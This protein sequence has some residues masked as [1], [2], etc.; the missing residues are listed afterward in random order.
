MKQTAVANLQVEQRAERDHFNHEPIAS[1]YPS[2]LLQPAGSSQQ[3]QRASPVDFA[4]PFPVPRGPQA[5]CSAGTVGPI[6][7]PW[8]H[9]PPSASYRR[10]CSRVALFICPLRTRRLS[11]VGYVPC[12]AEDIS[13]TS[14]GGL[15]VGYI[16]H[17]HAICDCDHPPNCPLPGRV[18]G[19]MSES[20][21]VISFNL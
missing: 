17:T 20:R 12:T 16:N 14:H 6:Q 1:L 5:S 21:K 7:G 4:V 13:G 15:C 18:C 11:G 8:Q 3:I 19:W 10:P 9:Q 2:L